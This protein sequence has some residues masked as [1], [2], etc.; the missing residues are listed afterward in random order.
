MIVPEDYSSTSS[1]ADSQ[2]DE[3]CICSSMEEIEEPDFKKTRVAVAPGLETEDELWQRR[4]LCMGLGIEDADMV[5][6]M[7]WCNLPP[8]L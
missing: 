7:V 5:R 1:E 8:V 4:A 6:R 3:S 2:E